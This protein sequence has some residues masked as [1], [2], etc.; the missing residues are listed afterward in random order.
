MNR[1]ALNSATWAISAALALALLSGGVLCAQEQREL[2]LKSAVTLALANSHAV[3]LAQAQYTVAKAEIAVNRSPFLPYLFTGSG[4][5]YTYGFPETPGGNPPSIFNLGYTQSIFDPVLRG[6]LRASRQ[7]AENQRLELEKTRDSVMVAAASDYLELAEVRHSLQLLRTERASQQSILDVTRDRVSSG[8]EL[9]MEA[10]RMELAQARVEQRIVQLEGRDEALADELR[11]LAGIHS[12]VPIEVSSEDLPGEPESPPEA[13]SNGAGSDLVNTVVNQA[14]AFSPD[15]KEA[16]NE[17][18]AETEIWKGARGA[19]W[20]TVSLV[21]EYSV[22]SRI[23]NYDQFYRTFQRNNV[24]IGIQLTIPIYDARTRANVALA[25]GQ[26][27]TAELAAG[28]KRSEVSLAAKQHLRDLR[29]A[30]AS[31]KVARLDLQ[32]SREG[33][34]ASQSRYDQGHATLRDL[35]RARVEENEK[36]LAFLEADFACQK[37]QLFLWQSTGELAQRLQ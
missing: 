4:L 29:E 15:I 14:I 19:Y 30:D 11:D 28:Q 12:G 16:L 22:L 18:T 36:W 34:D 23:N 24:N 26:L 6:Q 25:H 2:T 10:T 13:A 1:A 32:L 7:R 35:E 21:G 17:K 20:P 37:T 33:L 31:R 8:L 5:A 27:V 9:P 3:A